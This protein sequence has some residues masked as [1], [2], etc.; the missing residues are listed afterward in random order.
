MQ[1]KLPVKSRVADK[2]KP[3]LTYYAELIGLCHETVAETQ[4]L[5]LL[6]PMGKKT[7][8]TSLFIRVCQRMDKSIDA[9][10]IAD[11]LENVSQI[12][13]QKEIA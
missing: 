8:A 3:M 9:K 10:E 12:N 1:T 11:K 5:K 7:T 2:Y 13:K 4:S 6:D